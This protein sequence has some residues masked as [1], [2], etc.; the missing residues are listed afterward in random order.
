MMQKIKIEPGSE[1]IQK[2]TEKMEKYRVAEGKQVF[3]LLNTENGN[4]HKVKVLKIDNLTYVA[5]CD[6]EDWHFRR[7]EAGEPCVHIY[8]VI[9][10]AE[11]EDKFELE[12][13]IQDAQNLAHPNQVKMFHDEAP[14]SEPAPE[15]NSKQNRGARAMNYQREW[16]RIK[17]FISDE[18]SKYQANMTQRDGNESMF[19]AGMVVGLREVMILMDFLEEVDEP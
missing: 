17:E 6:C 1:L 12:N 9:Y 18:I 16:N 10:R 2:H 5:D 3:A 13:Y 14:G 15:S 8:T 11:V 19:W 7:K 4:R